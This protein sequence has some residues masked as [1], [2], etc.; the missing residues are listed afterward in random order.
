V[1]DPMME[2]LARRLDRLERENRRLRVVGL[3]AV[4]A[5][6]AALAWPNSRVTADEVVAGTLTIRDSSTGVVVASLES[7]LGGGELRLRTTDHGSLV[8]VSARPEARGGPMVVLNAPPAPN[9]NGPATASLSIFDDG[10]PRLHLNSGD[11][12][13]TLRIRGGGNPPELLIESR[14]GRRLAV[15]P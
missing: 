3:L 15:S 5:M 9:T 1:A 6:L 4:G 11:E 10:R 12:A 14:D 7:S 13:A 8:V 2:S